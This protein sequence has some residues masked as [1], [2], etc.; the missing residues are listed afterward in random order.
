LSSLDNTD[1]KTRPGSNGAILWLWKLFS[2]VR[3]AVI[4]ILVI[5]ALS[6]IGTFVASAGFFHS[7]WFLTPGVLLMLNI[8]ICSINRWPNLRALIRGAKIRQPD[9]FFRES[10]S[11][12]EPIDTPLMPVQASARIEELLR[13]QGYR[14]RKESA[15]DRVYL[16]ADKNRYFRLATF[17]SHLSLILFVLAYILGSSLGF[18]DTNFVVSEGETREIGHNTGLA[19]KLESFEDE[20]YADNRPQDFRSQVTV[21]KNG[22]EVDQALIRVNH[23]LY[24]NGIRFYQS[25]FGPAIQI[26]V[27]QDG[28]MVFQGNLAL[29][30][31]MAGQGYQRYVGTLQGE[32]GVAVRFIS[33]A[34]N[35]PD[36]MIP[37]GQLAVDVRQD[38][39]QVGIKLLEKAVPLAI[40][41]LEFTYQ[42]D[43][44][45]S[46]FQ[47]SRDPGNTLIWIASSLFIL[48][49]VLVLYFTHRQLWVMVQPS[50]SGQSQLSLRLINP[51]GFSNTA[52]LIR[53]TAIINKE[54]E[55]NSRL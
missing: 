55:K 24:Y 36:P 14:V 16:A 31:A 52:E 5:T 22:Q 51:R 33:S 7:W 17:A 2:S 28:E 50:T 39:Q 32:Q 12:I 42:S 26:Q 25:F 8:L 10:K 54:L 43:A 3:L 45:Y 30:G 19:L 37:E 44:Q 18:K 1:I 4:L 53:L 34:I 41:G 20:Y 9:S 29:E 21:Y 35:A 40:G 48:G 6:L 11:S 15:P 47:V 23:P 46:G 27:K 49:M 38:G 13:Q